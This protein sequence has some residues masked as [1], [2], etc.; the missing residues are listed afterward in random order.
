MVSNLETHSPFLF[1]IPR[2]S[3][4]LFQEMWREK[5][6]NQLQ[7][8]KICMKNLY[9]LIWRHFPKKYYIIKKDS[10]NTNTNT[11][12]NKS[13]QNKTK[14]APQKSPHQHRV[15]WRW[16][17]QDTFE[18][19]RAPRAPENP[20]SVHILSQTHIWNPLKAFLTLPST[21]HQKELMDALLISNT[22][23]LGK[24]IDGPT[25]SSNWRPGCCTTTRPASPPE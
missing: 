11:N 14:K 21:T 13:K 5:C 12:T 25:G 23:M 8:L 16:N 10:Q 20:I 2:S 22:Q 9:H 24:E 3:P 15:L 7:D 19:L 18:I 4:Y 6:L 17:G 1:L